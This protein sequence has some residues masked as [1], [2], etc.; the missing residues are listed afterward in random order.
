S[1][2]SSK[3]IGLESIE[4]GMFGISCRQAASATLQIFWNVN[5]STNIWI[6]NVFLFI[7]KSVFKTPIGS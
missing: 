7:H 3:S 5:K 2:F 1:L 6:R 4:L